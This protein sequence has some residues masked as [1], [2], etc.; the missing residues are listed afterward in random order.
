MKQCLDGIPLQ[1][2]PDKL[3][4]ITPSFFSSAQDTTAIDNIMFNG[5]EAVSSHRKMNRVQTNSRSLF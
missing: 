3:I 1:T 4:M 2:A 5:T